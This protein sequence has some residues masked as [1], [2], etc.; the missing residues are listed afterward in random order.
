MHDSL[1]EFLKI[2]EKTWYKHARV[3][4]AEQNCSVPFEATRFDFLLD[5]LPFAQHGL[6]QEV[7]ETIKKQTASYAW[8]MY[9]KRTVAIESDIITPLCNNV[10]NGSFK[11]LSDF[12]IQS[13]I[14]QTLV[15]EGYHTLLSLM[16]ID[17]IIQNRK[18]DPLNL[19][20]FNFQTS[21]HQRID[22]FKSTNKKELTLLG[23][24]ISSEVLISDY[25]ENLS[26]SKVVQPFCRE[27]TRTHWQD[28]LAHANIFKL[29]AKQLYHILEKE[30]RQLLTDTIIDASN[31]FCD[32][33]LDNWEKVLLAAECPRTTEIIDETRQTAPIVNHQLA[34]MRIDKLIKEMKDSPF[35][36]P[37]VR[38][39]GMIC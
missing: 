23:T 21:M 37:R 30:D 29:I 12:N 16:G 35:P 6:W 31:W 2:K 8:V 27:V 14:A 34:R 22:S 13:V 10:L 38:K 20:P 25:L 28:E 17:T 18:L 24:V 3:T 26:T 19:G 33:D 1:D 39:E 7:S 11:L 4:T 32:R 15:D 9:N 36:A 5:L